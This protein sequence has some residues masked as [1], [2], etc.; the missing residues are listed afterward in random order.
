MLFLL[1]KCTVNILCFSELSG[2]FILSCDCSLLNIT[3]HT[4]LWIDSKLHMVDFHFFYLTKVVLPIFW[5]I[6]Y[7]S[8]SP[9]LY[10]KCNKHEH[11]VFIIDSV[12]KLHPLKRHLHLEFIFRI[13]CRL[14]SWKL[15]INCFLP[16][17]VEPTDISFNHFMYVLFWCFYR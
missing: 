11:T 6:I 1:D 17:L 10:V 9:F 12:I 4:F 2:I 14:M 15:K 8:K 5:K 3:C 7:I 16:C 13:L